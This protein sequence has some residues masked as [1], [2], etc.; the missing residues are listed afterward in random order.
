MKVAI[1]VALDTPAI[2][3][4]KEIAVRDSRSL[5]SVIRMATS[6]YVRKYGGFNKPTA[7]PRRQ[8]SQR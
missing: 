3:R 2:R 1:S 5:S 4:L 6:E 8:V 7:K